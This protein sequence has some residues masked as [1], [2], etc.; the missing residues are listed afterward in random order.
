MQLVLC[1]NFKSFICIGMLIEKYSNF[2]NT[3][4]LYVFLL[5][6]CLLAFYILYFVHSNT[7]VLKNFTLHLTYF[8]LRIF[9]NTYVFFVL[10]IISLSFCHDTSIILK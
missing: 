2:Y 3:Y 8:T 6:Y 1:N 10:Y 9:Y 5:T 7:T 4:V